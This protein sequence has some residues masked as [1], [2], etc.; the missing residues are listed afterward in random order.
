MGFIGSQLH[1]GVAPGFEFGLWLVD[2]IGDDVAPHGHE[3]AHFMWAVTGA[4]T[5]EAEGSTPPGRDVLVFNPSQTYHADRFETAGAAFFSVTIDPDLC[6]GD[7]GMRLP[8]VPTHI[9]AE[10]ARTTLR[11]L[12][13]CAAL[14]E[15]AFTAE[16]LC[17]ELLASVCA[18]DRSERTAPAWLNRVCEIVQEQTGLSVNDV[19]LEAGVHP[20]HL[21]R[22]FR[23]HL[24]CT[25]GE[26]MRSRRLMKA[27]RLL[28]ESRTPISE[29][30]V[31]SGFTD[32]SHLTRR[33]VD[34]FGVTPA[35][36]R[37]ESSRCRDAANC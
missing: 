11:R 36:F 7:G 27:A 33:Y 3:E 26:F 32:Q 21:I 25:P 18:Q 5:T 29:I 20:T 12:L 8:A 17:Y 22:T 24:N 13:R 16:E 23:T 9:N 1:S 14:G 37:K 30:A 35:S 28:T 15:D 10:A 4:Y 34:A 31:L 2:R 19:A 6:A